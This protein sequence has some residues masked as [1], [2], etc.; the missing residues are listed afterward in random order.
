MVE[1]HSGV[2]KVNR[3]NGTLLGIATIMNFVVGT[4]SDYVTVP[5]LFPIAMVA[6]GVI[7]V[8]IN[9]MWGQLKWRVSLKEFLFFSIFTVQVLAGTL[10]NLSS[11]SLYYAQCFLCIG[12]PSVF[13]ATRKIDYDVLRHTVLVVAIVSVSHFISILLKEYTV[14]T[15]EEQMGN[16][17]SL[18]AILFTAGW[19]L[20]DSKD[21]MF[22]KGISVIVIVLS[23]SILVKVMT[24]GAWLCA[25]V[26]VGYLIWKKLKNKRL[27][28]AIIVFAPLLLFVLWHICT[29][30]IS[31]TKWFAN[32]FQLKATDLLN[33][34]DNL[35][36][37]AVEY[38]GMLKT[39]F[40]SG[41][42]AYYGVYRTYP[43][44]I[45]AQLYYD[46]GLIAVVIVTGIIL[47]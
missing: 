28:L 41:V 24:R 47:S 39:I 26:F 20:L 43:H 1:V 30:Y 32:M 40:G 3:I 16:A 9:A 46:Q 45:F 31:H 34:R 2:E 33:G 44:N 17:Y 29:K 5:N 10:L 35:L 6:L 38:R 4:I 37:N 13:L 23:L 19:T 12:I 15:S 27:F 14:Y 11:N 36:K 21:R 7:A 18:L 25:F 22:W 8:G 42:G